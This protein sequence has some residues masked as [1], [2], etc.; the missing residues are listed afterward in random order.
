MN[1]I[2][3]NSKPNL[4]LWGGL[5]AALA[6]TLYYATRPPPPQAP[7]PPLPPQPP[8]PSQGSSIAPWLIG[9]WGALYSKLTQA[10]LPADPGMPAATAQVVQTELQADTD[11]VSLQNLAATLGSKGYINSSSALLAKAYLLTAPNSN[12]LYT[13]LQP[14]A[15]PTEQALATS[16]P[17][18]GQRYFVAG[19]AGSLFRVYASPPD[20]SSQ[21]GAGMTDF[22]PPANVWAG[23]AVVATGRT[24]GAVPP[25][26]AYWEALMLGSDGLPM[27]A[28]ISQLSLM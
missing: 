25:Q 4:L 16:S 24:N 8:H 2:A 5:A 15:L 1:G 20:P 11:A 21:T 28:W 22:N 18:A 13:A 19:T 6:V 3:S 27:V 17:V 10:S 9:P 12:D 26:S 23:S 14:G 7:P